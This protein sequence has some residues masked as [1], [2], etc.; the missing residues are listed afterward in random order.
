MN[1][2][3]S[4]LLIL[5]LS[6]PAFSSIT[7]E[8]LHSLA[9]EYN[10]EVTIIQ[11]PTE[12]AFARNGKI[13]FYK[14]YLDAPYMTELYAKRTLF[15]EMAHISNNHIQIIGV[16]LNLIRLADQ[17]LKVYNNPSVPPEDFNK[18][19]VSFFMFISRILELDADTTAITKMKKEGYDISICPKVFGNKWYA[20]EMGSTHPLDKNRVLNCERIFNEK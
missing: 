19:S 7:E 14:G 13:Y 9:K 10:Q 17:A 3:L 15:H 16:T 12:N 20:D 1:K 5:F 8:Q 11:E 4:T 2:A 6:L 18:L